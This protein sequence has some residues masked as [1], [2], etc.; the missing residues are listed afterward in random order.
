MKKEDND[1]SLLIPDVE[2]MNQEP[3]DLPPLG[4]VLVQVP[5][6]CECC[7]QV[8]LDVNSGQMVPVR[9]NH[10]HKPESNLNW[11]LVFL[12]TIASAALV[13]I[14]V[15]SQQLILRHMVANQEMME[16][17]TLEL[18]IPESGWMSNEG[19]HHK[20]R[21][22][23]ETN[24]DYMVEIIQMDDGR[25]VSKSQV[26]A[27]Y[28][29]IS[30]EKYSAPKQLDHHEVKFHSPL[31]LKNK[32]DITLIQDGMYWS[33]KVINNVDPGL[34][35][36]TIQAELRSL[37]SRKVQSLEEPTWLKCGREQNRFVT[38]SD[39]VHA[40]A[41][42]REPHNQLVLGEV[43]SFYLARL[44]G[45]HNVPAVILSQVDPNNPVWK[46]AM[47]EVKSSEWRVGSIVAMIQW[48]EDLVRDKMPDILRKALLARTTLDGTS[49]DDTYS[50]LP[51]DVTHVNI[52]DLSVTEAA[53]L[54]QWSDLVV[55][56][57]LT[58]N[59]D[60]VASMQDAAEKENHPEVLSETVHNLAKSTRTGSLWLIDNESGM[61]DAYS[62]L[63]PQFVDNEAKKEANRFKTM[64]QDMLQTT[65]IFKRSTVDKIFGLYKNGDTVSVLNDFI[66]R[67][68]PFYEE[69]LRSI[70]GQDAA[71]KEHFQERVEE[72][73]T[74]MKQCQE[75]V[76]F[77]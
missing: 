6:R 66:S 16:P 8:M 29:H 31:T 63:Y 33:D 38:F 57:Y 28:Y 65:C 32:N 42:Y 75:N 22:P 45:I 10:N 73:W 47:S 39:G 61:L 62:L 56:D 48:V 43:M 20:L 70:P 40:C 50:D 4:S 25:S 2:T 60:R 53:E 7:P 21:Y 44:L 76:K 17:V 14:V 24:E 26:S 5:P 64:H 35:E 52:R 59:Y 3:L 58:A 9:P 41:R 51:S 23:G 77:W 11:K 30:P 69:L 1:L 37:R 27:A 12:L 15:I 55:F 74:W 13:S 36:E 67:S 71:Y 72:V 46:S 19:L 34:D 18:N 49:D 54:A 68:E